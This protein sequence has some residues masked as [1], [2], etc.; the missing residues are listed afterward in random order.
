MPVKRLEIEGVGPVK[1]HKRK[2]TRAMRIRISG[3]EVSVS[4]PTW[5]PYTA[6]I[7]FV[8]SKKAWILRNKQEHHTYEDG[9]RIGR[10]HHLRLIHDPS[11]AAP[12]SRSSDGVITVTY[13]TYNE[14]TV[15][16]IER[17]AKRALRAEAESYLLERVRHLSDQTGIRYKSLQCKLLKGRWGSCDSHNNL[18]FN[19]YLVQ[20]PWEL[21]KY[22]II[23]ELA[24]TK[25]HNHSSA[26][27]ELVG[28]HLPDY[29]VH[30]KELKAY[31]PYILPT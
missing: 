24:H 4:L 13:A 7:A 15:E 10:Q 23:H 16:V 2:G 26:F 18:V 30:R 12:R 27:W 3:P 8:Q 29:K 6:A 9:T 11:A 20:L 17:A 31:H 21:I 5:V 25:H 22:V 14:A 1:L 19:I 28:Q